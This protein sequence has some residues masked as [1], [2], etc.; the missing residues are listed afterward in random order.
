MNVKGT[1]ASAVDSGSSRVVE[2]VRG[3]APIAPASTAAAGAGQADSLSIS[4]SARS[5]A[6]LQSIIAGT[7]DIN[8]E[9]VARV[10]KSIESGQYT[11]NAAR[12]ADRM[13]QLERDLGAATRQTPR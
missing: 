8:G 12:I 13:L 6:N 4:G 9:R 3:S 7:P 5:L 2:P 10:S 1:D 11:V